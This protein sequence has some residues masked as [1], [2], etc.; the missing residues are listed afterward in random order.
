MRWDQIPFNEKASPEQKADE[1]NR[2]LA[3]N[4]GPTPEE[5][6]EAA[7]PNR[8]ACKECK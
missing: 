6:E 4:N 7:R 3:E 5:L 2:Q 1:F 8:D